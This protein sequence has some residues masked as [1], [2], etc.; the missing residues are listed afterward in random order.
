M[1]LAVVLG[2]VKDQGGAVSV[3]SE[4]GKGSVFIVF[5]PGSRPKSPPG[6]RGR[7][8]ADGPRPYPPVDDEKV[9]VVSVKKALERLGY[10]V[11]TANLGQEALD[12]FLRDPEAYDLLIT[13]QTMPHM[14]GLELAKEIIRIKPDAYRL[15]LRIQRDRRRGRGEVGGDPPV[16]MKPFSLREMAETVASAKKG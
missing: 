2:I 11:T 14:T 10:T 16:P 6:R 1:G 15:E 7:R 9:Q 4:P 12:L 5:F 3:Y 8:A 13:D